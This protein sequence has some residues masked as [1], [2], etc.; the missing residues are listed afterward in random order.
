M[1]TILQGP[2]R[3]VKEKEEVP[4]PIPRP[5]PPFGFVEIPDPKIPDAKQLV[6][7]GW[8]PDVPDLRDYTDKHPEILKF[9]ENM[10]IP[11]ALKKM[12]GAPALPT[13]V[14]LRP[15]CSPVENQMML[16]SCTANAA[17]GIVEYFENRAFGKHLDG[18]R[19]FVYKTTRD[20]LGLVGDTGAYLRT[21]MAALALFGVPPETYWPYTDAQQPGITNERT[22]DLEPTTFVYEMADNFESINYFCHDPF[23]T[24]VPPADVLN[25]VKT[26]LAYNIPT[27]FGF[28]VFPS[29]TQGDVKGAF[30][31][32]APG[33][34]AFAGHAVVAVGYND[35]MKITNLASKKST[36]GALLLRNS[37]GTA[38]G[39]HGY[40]WLPY[41]YVLHQLAEDFWSLISMKWIDLEKFQIKTLTAQP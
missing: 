34:K 41:D 9:T 24:P 38:W 6:G 11:K 14:D 35:S 19:L 10:G 13:S 26:Y 17:V 16:G 15:W 21:T 40:G 31:F 12:K 2:P 5:F 37:W 8:I 39:D 7:T 28:W 20:L 23:G 30:P 32:P 18:S 27:M 25:S 3:V 29:Y 4:L 36:T 22:F 33:E 1:A